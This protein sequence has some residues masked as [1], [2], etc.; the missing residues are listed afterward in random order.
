MSDFIRSLFESGL[1]T[2]PSLEFAVI[3]GC[4]RINS[5]SVFTGLNNLDVNS[6]LSSNYAEY[7]GFTQS[8]VDAMLQTYGIENREKEIRRWYDGYLF[9]NTD[10]YNPWSVVNYVKAAYHDRN[11]LPRPYWANTSSNSIVRELVEHADVNIRQELERLLEGGYVETLVHEDVTYEEIHESQDNL[12]NF[13]FFTGY[14]KKVKERMQMDSIYISLA[15]PNAEVRYIYRSTIMEWFNR[16]VRQEN[17]SPLYEALLNQ[18]TETVEKVLSEYLMET[19][20]FFDYKEDYYHG[21]VTGM[22]TKM[23][24]YI[25]QSNRENGLGRSNIVLRS[26]PYEGRAIIIEIKVAQ[27]YVEMEKTAHAALM[28]IEEKKY[29][30]TLKLEGYHTFLNYGI[31][32]YKKMC[33]A[34]AG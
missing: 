13:L 11:A 21:F 7:F 14:L 12:W 25:V 33:R 15:I 28:Q 31:A 18:D 2:N 9:G 22:L 3:T 30:E 23:P 8:E 4:L 24:G 19:I 17:F 6:V 5:E 20:S 32:F 34:E 29:D 26:A 16:R 1:K 10:V 27:T